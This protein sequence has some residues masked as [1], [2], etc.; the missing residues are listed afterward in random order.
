MRRVKSN[1]FVQPYG[2][3]PNLFGLCHGEKTKEDPTFSSS[4]MSRD[5]PTNER[6]ENGVCS[7]Y[8]ERGGRQSQT[9]DE[10]QAYKVYFRHESSES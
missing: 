8:P 9:K 10:I 7:S 5:E 1:V 6:E 3:K 4:H 2:Q